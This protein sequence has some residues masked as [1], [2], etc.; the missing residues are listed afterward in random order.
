M[1]KL[2]IVSLLS[3]SIL[4][5][6]CAQNGIGVSAGH[7]SSLSQTFEVG[8]VIDQKKVLIDKGNLAG[9]GTGAAVGAAT[10]AL[11]GSRSSGKNAVKGG[12]IGAVVGT[13]GGYLASS[14]SGG[15][16]VEAYE[17]QIESKSGAIHKTY[18][19]YD[20][21]LGTVVEYIVRGD[22]SITNID[23]KKP[24]KRVN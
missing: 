12:V 5:S 20:L 7:S 19:E 8:T 11:L 15:N 18:V 9:M 16:E 23:I 6:G 4:F 13:A 14:L 3:A 10:G 2:L 24:G 17:I 21:P 1:K 22:G